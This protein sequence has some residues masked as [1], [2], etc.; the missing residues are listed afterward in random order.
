MRKD[1]R[2][3]RM[4][5]ILIHMDHMDEPATSDHIAT[6]LQTNPVV[7]RRT[8]GCLRDRGYVTSIKGHGG[9]WLLNV[10]LADITLLDIHTALGESSVFTIGLSDEHTECLI[11]KAVNRELASAL[12]ASEDL[13]LARFGEVSLDKLAF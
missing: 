7:V 6:M 9:G 1:S 2:L 13:L 3:S 11:E 4:L 12:K 8:M 10:S 5:H